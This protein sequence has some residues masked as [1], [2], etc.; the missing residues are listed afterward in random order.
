MARHNL[1][2][3]VTLPT[4]LA[5]TACGGDDQA[6]VPTAV[7]PLVPPPVSQPQPTPAPTPPYTLTADIRYGDGPTTGGAIPLSL[8]LYQP[9]QSCTAPRP[10]V[11]YVHGGG[12]TGGSRKGASVE[13][14]ASELAPLGINLVSIQYRL[15]GNAPTISS[16]FTRFESDYQGLISNQTPARVRAF[17]AAVEDSVRALRW[18]QSNAN[19]FCI[20]PGNLGL[21]GS[22]AGAYTVLHVA[23]SLNPY[24]IARPAPRVVVDYW[25]GLFR[26]SDIEVNET[27]LF[28]LHGTADAVV[29]FSEATELTARA[30]QVAVPFTFYSV[31]NGGHDFDGSGFFVRRV[32]GQSIAK[33]TADFVN[34]HLRTGMR[35]LY[36]SRTVD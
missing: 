24:S 33:R 17:V 6:T 30:R 25:G 4:L 18:M 35:P 9:S 13:A 2:R 14:I 20:D 27:P 21:W 8:D 15:E 19:Q 5:L 10:T 16:E 12:F 23:Y 22:S 1:A 3:Y 28:V 36:E 7:A 29:P 31:T 11:L 34:A 26:D 32:D